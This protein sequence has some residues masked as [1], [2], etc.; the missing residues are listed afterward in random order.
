M[1]F[2]GKAHTVGAHVDTDAI[3][4]AQYLVST[5]PEV[6]GEHC[7]AGLDPDWVKNVQSGD[8]VVAGP[9]FGCG[10]SREHAPLALLGA[11]IPVV[12]AHSFARIFYRNGFNM[13]L[14]L[15]EVGDEV[16]SIQEGDEL[17]VDLDQGIILDVSN[18]REI[19]FS[20]L[21]EFMKDLL[22]NGGLVNY[23]RKRLQKTDDRSQ[24]C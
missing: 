21:P 1:Q 24:F 11:G 10:S 2:H 5:A 6:L 18:S 16:N 14:I 17:Q 22:E 19:R 3:I 23:V 12:I 13:G 8:V 9:N 20:P 7:L 15:L 4:A